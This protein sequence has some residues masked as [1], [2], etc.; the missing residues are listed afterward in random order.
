M[1]TSGI[2]QAYER[3]VRHLAAHVQVAEIARGQAAEGV[4]RAQ[5]AL[6]VTDAAKWDTG[7]VYDRGTVP[8]M[9]GAG[10]ERLSARLATL[11]R[12]S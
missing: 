11:S 8:R 7:S 6:F 3:G 4:N 2:F 10:E 1:L 5:A 12:L 9:L